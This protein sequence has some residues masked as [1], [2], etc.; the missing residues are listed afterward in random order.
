MIRQHSTPYWQGLDELTLSGTTDTGTVFEQSIRGEYQGETLDLRRVVVRL[1]QP[2]RDGDS[3]IAILTNLPLVD[4]D[5]VAIAS[6]K[7]LW[8]R[9]TT[10][11]NRRPN[12]TGFRHLYHCRLAAIVADL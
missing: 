6:Q 8:F 10:T 11:G 9:K 1:K 7:W 5:A 3:E 2:T 4:A 12:R